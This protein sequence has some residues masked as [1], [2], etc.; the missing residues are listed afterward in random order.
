MSRITLELLKR[1][2]EHNDG[3]LAELEELSLHQLEL[4]SIEILGTTCRRLRI[5]YLQNNIIPR[6]EGLH[7]L[8]DLRYLNAALNN[9]TV[10]EGLR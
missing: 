6:L 7:H 3:T 5:L 10:I 4:E 8:K 9:I 2:S 1:K